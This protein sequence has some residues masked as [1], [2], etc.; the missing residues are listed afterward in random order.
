MLFHNKIPMLMKGTDIRRPD[1][2]LDWIVKRQSGSSIMEVT[3]EI[4][5]DL[6]RYSV[7]PFDIL[8]LCLCN[9]KIFLQPIHIM[10]SSNSAKNMFSM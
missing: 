6:G 3:D 4:L 10:N 1:E 8:I 7:L 2:T 5:S 9:A